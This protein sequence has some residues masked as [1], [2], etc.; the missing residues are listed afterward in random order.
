MATI[1]VE[2]RKT[3]EAG[4]F[5]DNMAATCRA[6]GH[7]VVRWR[8]PR[9]G[10]V[11]YGRWMWPC[12]LAILFNGTHERYARYHRQLDHWGAQRIY[13]ELGWYPQQGRFQ[14]DPHGINGA[15][16]W[17]G[18]RLNAVCRTPLAVPTGGDLLV[19]LQHDH[20]TQITHM[21]PWFDSMFAFV[22]HLAVHSS[23]PLR[24]RKHPRH[25]LDGR[26]NELARAKG[27]TW[28]QSPS[29]TTAME[30]CCAVACINSSG[31]VEALAHRLPVL[32]F[33]KAVYRHPEAVLCLTDDGHH[34][35]AI[36]RQLGMGRC[37]LFVEAVDATVRRIQARQWTVTQI[38]AR[39]PPLLDSL[40]AG[41]R[42]LT[43][44][45]R[46]SDAFPLPRAA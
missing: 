43:W 39:L 28:D 14:V 45:S 25:D 11:P 32:C 42:P 7:R 29:L 34:L 46:L 27:L 33:G 26:L 6:A 20:D 13:V 4:A 44:W 36:T 21:S 12:D 19:V 23:L 37:D 22:Q 17:A 38:P 30:T 5:L 9:S 40:L 16:S 3:P 10:R 18:E 8:G 41:R 2:A 31:A 1:L 15:A 24:L 35:R